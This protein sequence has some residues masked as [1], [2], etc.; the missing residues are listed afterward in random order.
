VLWYHH[1]G[2]SYYRC[3][4]YNPKPGKAK[5]RSVALRADTIE[6]MVWTACQAVIRKPQVI[7]EVAERVVRE[8]QEKHGD[9]FKETERLQRAL[10]ANSAAKDN[11]LEL[12]RRG[13]VS[14]TVA[15]THLEELAKEEAQLRHELTML[16]S[17]AERLRLHLQVAQEMER[18][19]AGAA[20]I[21]DTTDPE[22]QRAMIE[23]L[24]SYIELKRWGKAGARRP[25]L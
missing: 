20:D 12:I 3:G 25:A 7:T 15:D 10:Q 22:Q 17:S 4:G 19:V 11:I 21:A 8:Y 6:G 1:S 24:I 13:R 14:L 18:M 9:V 2:L 23:G 16:D 5:C